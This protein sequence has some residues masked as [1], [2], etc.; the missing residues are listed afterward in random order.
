VPDVAVCIPYRAGVPERE[1]NFAYSHAWWLRETD[2]PV[3]VGDDEAEPFFSAGR[4]RNLAA[5]EAGEWDVAVFSDAD[6]IPGSGAQ[7]RQAVDTAWREGA[8][9]TLHHE[10]RYVEEPDAE[11]VCA[12]ELP[13]MARRGQKTVGHTWVSS[14]AV[15]RDLFE[16]VGGYDWRIHG[17]GGEDLAFYF[18]CATF[19]GQ[20]RTQGPLFHLAH[21]SVRE[22]N[23]LPGTWTVVN[24]YSA[25]MF[26]KGAMADVVAGNVYDPADK[27]A[28]AQRAAA[29]GSATGG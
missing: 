16:K 5:A 20:I 1:R 22:T 25:A 21:P 15:R 24:A 3:F 8:Y 28:P 9:V 17:Y 10:I 2:W 12:G 23:S 6:M 13:L 29:G 4:S 18:A 27:N 11:L 19:G 7:V 26:D 14:C